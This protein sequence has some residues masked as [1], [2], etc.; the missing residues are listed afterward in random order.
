MGF[1][2]LK[3][4]VCAGSGKALKTYDYPFTRAT[5]I[6]NCDNCEGTG[7][8]TVHAGSIGPSYIMAGPMSDEFWSKLLE[9]GQA[10]YTVTLTE[11]GRLVK[12]VVDITKKE[13]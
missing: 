11:D 8:I 12:E 2:T 3:C 9:Q 13:V 4:S 1:I 7:E 10:S 6:V 5:Q